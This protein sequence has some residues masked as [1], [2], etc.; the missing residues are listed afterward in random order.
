MVTNLQTRVE[1]ILKNYNTIRVNSDDEYYFELI[2]ILQEK[3][4][5]HSDGINFH[6]ENN[7]NFEFLHLV[8]IYT[9][10]EGITYVK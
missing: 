6:R 5:K 3:N 7:S 9:W 8:D 10:N 2:D 4:W 1:N